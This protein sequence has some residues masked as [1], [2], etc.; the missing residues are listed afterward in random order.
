MESHHIDLTY[1]YHPSYGTETPDQKKKAGT[2]K[3]HLKTYCAA[4]FFE[5][6]E[7]P[8]GSMHSSPKPHLCR[9]RSL[10]AGTDRGQADPRHSTIMPAYDSTAQ[11]DAYFLTTK[12]P[13]KHKNIGAA[14][15]PKSTLRCMELMKSLKKM[16]SIEFRQYKSREGLYSKAHLA[17]IL[18]LIEE[19]EKNAEQLSLMARG[20]ENGASPAVSQ[21]TPEMRK[22]SE[23][24]RCMNHFLS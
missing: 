13:E 12:N 14:P 18:G 24:I 1:S 19:S 8:P 17:G 16:M 5:P 3:K 20:E 6:E 2:R 11:C 15:L 4:D 7:S 21:E 9:S 22:L 10:W 23:L